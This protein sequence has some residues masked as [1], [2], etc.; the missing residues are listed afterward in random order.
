[1][2]TSYVI[3]DLKS[4]MKYGF[5]VT[6]YNSFGSS[7]AS[8]ILYY[9]VPS[10][11]TPPLNLNIFTTKYKSITSSLLQWEPPV[12]NGGSEITSYQI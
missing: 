7:P 12:S 5:M 2:K 8:E 9:I 6:A 3:N 11:S 4:G 10:I 1:M